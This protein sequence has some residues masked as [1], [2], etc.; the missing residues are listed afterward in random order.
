MKK[1]IM[2]AGA[3]AAVTAAAL[4]SYSYIPT[5][6][7]KLKQKDSRRKKQVNC[8]G[9]FDREKVLYLT[10]DDGPD[11][12]YTESMLNMLSKHGVKATFFVVADFAKENPALIKRMKEE[13]HVI[14]LHSLSHNS[15]M[16]ET[17]GQTRIA[18]KNALDVMKK[19]GVDVKYYRPPWG[20]VNIESLKCIREYGLKKV[21]WDVM[22]EDWRGDTSDEEIQYRLLKRSE[23]GDI[24]CLHDGRGKNEA[25]S[26]TLA[27]LDKTI[28]LWLEEGFVFKTIDEMRD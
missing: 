21:L 15:A 28:P 24:I 7:G 9:G 18:F 22:A 1:N 13:G 14:G 10:F 5:I 26:R 8:A 3:L 16:I 19:L 2:T 25:P 27:A 17:P 20:H 12:V 6:W 23:S 4:A 11:K